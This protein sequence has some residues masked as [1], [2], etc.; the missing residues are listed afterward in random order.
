MSD[1]QKRITAAFLMNSSPDKAYEWLSANWKSSEEKKF[2][3]KFNLGRER[4]SLEYLLLRR[5]NPLIDL[6]LAQFGCSPYALKT[7]FNRGN[8]G[9]RCAVLVN[10]QLF[11][12]DFNAVIDLKEIINRRNRRELEALASNSHLPDAFYMH[13]INRT[14]YFSDLGESDFQLMLCQL[15]DNLRISTPYDETYLCGYS[16]YSYHNVFTAAWQLAATVPVTLE[17]AVVLCKLL[18]KAQAPVGLEGLEQIIERWYI[19]SPKTSDDR[20]YNDGC[21]YYLR[22]RLADLLNADDQLLNSEDL[23]LRQS[24]YRRFSPWEFNNWPEFL[25]KDGEEFVQDAMQNLHL[26]KSH[27][28]R[29]ELEKVAWDCPDPSHDMMM[30]NI[31][32]SCEKSHREEHPEWFHEEESEYSTDSNAVARRTEILLKSISDRIISSIECNENIYHKTEMLL[33]SICNRIE[34]LEN[35]RVQTQKKW[36]SK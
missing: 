22:S 13:L 25:A 11:E 12:T 31:F 16:D 3:Q 10:P 30:P 36:W 33:E 27:N 8:T 15:G 17:W 20:Y 34:S 18:R 29:Q 35:E 14:D 6:G 24:F 5:K 4:K 9:V 28:N 7:V 1:Y 32:R 23:A 2:F 21:G 26:W 19:D